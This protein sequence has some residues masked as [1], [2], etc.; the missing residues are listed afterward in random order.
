MRGE[1]LGF[2]LLPGAFYTIRV[3][4][5]E[6]FRC[7]GCVRLCVMEPVPAVIALKWQGKDAA[8]AGWV[9]PEPRWGDS[10]T[11]GRRFQNPET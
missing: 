9:N 6:F 4:P 5:C 10:E 3:G 8:V 11:T 7:Y 1:F 2:Q